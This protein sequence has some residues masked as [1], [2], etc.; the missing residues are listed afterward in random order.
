MSGGGGGGGEEGGAG[1]GGDMLFNSIAEPF[2]PP[3][4][5]EVYLFFVCL[6]VV[7]GCF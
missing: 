7:L 2:L 6:L 3:A 4:D 1:G 5:L